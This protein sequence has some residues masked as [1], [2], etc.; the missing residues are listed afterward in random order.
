MTLDKKIDDA[1]RILKL[2]EQQAR[3]YNE[4]VEIAYSGGKDSDVILTLAKKSGINFIAIYKNTTIDP[5]GTKKHV[6]ENNVNIIN[7][8]QNFF[9]LIEKKGLPSMFRRFCCAELKEYKVNNVA[10]IGVRA[11]ESTRRAKRYKNFEECRI[12]KNGKVHQ[13]YPIYNWENKDVENFIKQ[14]EIKLADCYYD[15]SG[16]IDFSRRLGCLACPLKS[17]RGLADF[18]KNKRFLI[19][20][21]KHFKRYVEKH[22]LKNFENFYEAFYCQIFTHSLNEFRLLKEQNLFSFKFDAKKRIE[23]YFDIELNF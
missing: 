20:Y 5:P 17:D 10:A 7:P 12:F 6:I 21:L 15:D 18:K 2:A 1:I 3:Q 19:A 8:K 14:E 22:P 16:S 4:P 13:Y 9:S 11:A 23:K